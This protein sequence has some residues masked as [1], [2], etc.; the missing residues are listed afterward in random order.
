MVTAK[1]CVSPLVNNA[2][3]CVLGNNPTSATIGRTVFVS[4]PSI[5]FPVFRIAE[6]TTFA[7]SSFM[8]PPTN[9]PSASAP[10]SST[11]FSLM[12]DSAPCLS[13]LS[14]IA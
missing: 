4:R 13:D 7:S 8:I 10:A 12:P 6:R 5:R 9:T 14:E 1:A 2:E 3:P 11:A